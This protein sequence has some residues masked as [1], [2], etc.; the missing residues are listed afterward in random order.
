M[1]D[2]VYMYQRALE[3]MLNNLD[4]SS[5]CRV[6]PT[7]TKEGTH[8]MA[9]ALGWEFFFKCD[10]ITQFK[11]D[12]VI[13]EIGIEHKEYSHSTKLTV[14]NIKALSGDFI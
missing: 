4:G 3:N 13:I 12:S 8:P 2:D 7:L 1:F 10:Q 6:N 14:E 9:N 5:N 11:P